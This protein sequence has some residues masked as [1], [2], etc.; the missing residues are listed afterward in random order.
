MGFLQQLQCLCVSSYS[1]GDTGDSSLTTKA[2]ISATAKSAPANIFT[3]V[4]GSFSLDAS[5]SLK[6]SLNFNALQ[7]NNDTADSEEDFII[8]V[9]G[10]QLDYNYILGKGIIR[11][12]KVTSFT[13][14]NFV[15]KG[16]LYPG[17]RL[18]CSESKTLI[19]SGKINLKTEKFAGELGNFNCLQKLYPIADVLNDGFISSA[20]STPLY[21]FIDEGVLS[22]PINKFIIVANDADFIQPSSY[23]TSGLFKYACEIDAP[24]VRPENSSFRFRARAPLFNRETDIPPKFSVNNILLKDP[25]GN[26]IVKYKDFSFFGDDQYTTYSSLPI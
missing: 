24:I 1:T 20:S 25:S 23:T 15:A 21:S 11:Q 26:L 8:P 22:G 12:P 9:S 17:L 10:Q 5:I 2:S 18:I 16:H 6:V 14:Q 19:N 3:S 4:K 13:R 7:Q